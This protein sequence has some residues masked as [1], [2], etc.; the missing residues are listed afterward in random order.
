[1]KMVICDD[2]P[3]DISYVTGLIDVWKRKTG[4]AVE[5]LSFPTAE[6]LLFAFEE[7]LDMDILQLDI[8]MGE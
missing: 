1:M 5:L 8:E 4:T 3:A 6:A 7:H 2:N